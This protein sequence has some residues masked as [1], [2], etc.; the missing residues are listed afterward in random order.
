MIIE[1]LWIS[2]SQQSNSKGHFPKYKKHHG[3]TVTT[4]K[5]RENVSQL[6]STVSKHMVS[7]TI[8]VG[9]PPLLHT[10]TFWDLQAPL[11]DK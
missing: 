5:K 9:T 6:C 7:G 1:C 8:R 4:G 10:F 11:I 3:D 2:V